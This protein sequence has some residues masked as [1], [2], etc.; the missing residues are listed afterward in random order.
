MYPNRK[1]N[2]ST[3]FARNG[4]TLDIFIMLKGSNTPR[5]QSII[6][7]LFFSYVSRNISTIILSF[8]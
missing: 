7:Y 5:Y 8:D 1:F 6:I 4:Q 2:I 3:C